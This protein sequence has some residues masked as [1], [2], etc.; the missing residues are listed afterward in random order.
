M[1]KG[2]STRGRM[3]MCKSDSSCGGAAGIGANG[4]ANGNVQISELGACSAALSLFS[5]CL[6][7]ALEGTETVAETEA[8][9]NFRNKLKEIGCLQGL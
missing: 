4:A 6:G 8:A 3:G 5:P 1:H 9:L 2:Q 7:V